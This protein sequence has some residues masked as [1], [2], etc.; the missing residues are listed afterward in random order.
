MRQAQS[1]FLRAKHLFSLLFYRALLHYWFSPCLLV[2]FSVFAFCPLIKILTK[3][4]KQSW[5]CMLL[6][7]RN[8]ASFIYMLE[9]DFC[10]LTKYFDL[11]VIMSCTHLL[12]QC[13]EAYSRWCIG[14]SSMPLEEEMGCKQSS[15]PTQ[16]GCLASSFLWLTTN[17]DHFEY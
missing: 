3:I 5:I 9:Q 10:S 16:I 15:L 7:P 1:S 11:L 14:H 13:V 8:F 17:I 2:I 4:W 6:L 12:E